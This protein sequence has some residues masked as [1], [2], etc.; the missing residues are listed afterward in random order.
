VALAEITIPKTP[1]EVAPAQ[2]ERSCAV[3]N[4][5]PNRVGVI[6]KSRLNRNVLLWIPSKRV[7]RTDCVAHLGAVGLTCGRKR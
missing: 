7:R 4:E 1:N 6:T 2:R 3:K 5:P